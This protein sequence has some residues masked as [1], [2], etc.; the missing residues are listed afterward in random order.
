MEKKIT[1]YKKW[2][3]QF[4]IYILLLNFLVTYLIVTTP[5]IVGLTNHREMLMIR[6]NVLSIIIL[7]LL[8]SGIVLTAMSFKNKED[9]NYQYKISIYGYPIYILISLIISFL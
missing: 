8:V 9:K 7:G 2:S 1:N 4:F 6:V 3:F 5:T